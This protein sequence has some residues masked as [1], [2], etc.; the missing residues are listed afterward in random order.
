MTHRRKM[1]R[2]SKRPLPARVEVSDWKNQNLPQQVKVTSSNPSVHAAREAAAMLRNQRWKRQADGE[3]S[4]TSLQPPVN[5][6]PQSQQNGPSVCQKCGGQMVADP[7]TGQQKCSCGNTQPTG[8]PTQAQRW[9]ERMKRDPKYRQ[10][11]MQD[12]REYKAPQRQEQQSQQPT[13]QQKRMEEEGAISAE[14][15]RRRLQERAPKTVDYRLE[16][17]RAPGAGGVVQPGA[18]WTSPGGA[19]ES[20]YPVSAYDPSMQSNRP[21]S[22]TDPSQYSVPGKELQKWWEYNQ[23]IQTQQQ[24]GPANVDDSSYADYLSQKQPQQQQG[25]WDKFKDFAYQQGLA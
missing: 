24:Q 8:M 25:W 1:D 21:R 15:A 18:R 9:K 23:P 20:Q 10:K 4:T 12:L 11:V 7:T 16:H 17:G 22:T 19:M 14:E 5:Q 3:S 6:Q 2:T 13:P